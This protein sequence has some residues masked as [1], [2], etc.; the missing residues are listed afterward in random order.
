M[1]GEEI[2]AGNVPTTSREKAQLRNGDGKTGV[3]EKIEGGEKHESKKRK[4]N[5]RRTK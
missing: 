4:R 5:R 2:A 3:R 1:G